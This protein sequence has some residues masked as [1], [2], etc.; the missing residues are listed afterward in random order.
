MSVSELAVTAT[1]MIDLAWTA[2]AA[3]ARE[4]HWQRIH[5][6]AALAAWLAGLQPTHLHF[7]SEF[8]EHLL[9]V[10]RSLR[11]AMRQAEEAG[12]RFV[13]LTPVASPAVLDRL[14]GLLPMLPA[15]TEVVANDWGVA[16]ELCMR[17]PAL[18]PVAGRVL[19][20]MTKDPR[21]DAGWAGRCGHGLASATTRALFGRLGIR[22]LELDMPVFAED[23]ALEGLPLPAGV[24][25]PYIYVAKG[26]MCRAGG[27][28]VTGAERFAVGR[29]CRKECLSVSAE[30]SRPGR[31]DA[32]PSI[33][34]GNTL[35]S[36]HSDAM[37]QAL[38]RAADAERI[39][40]LVVAGE[41]L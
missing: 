21:V 27:L 38:R 23:G 28:S 16:H 11:Q 29:R 25:L 15:G 31:S 10:E 36:R 32:C 12:L 2:G 14:H 8:C 4:R 18:R 40:R 39:G 5:G 24:H 20:R 3:A 9:P 33:Q 35:F 26:R 7:G 17:F 37:A 30:A 34:L 13:L 19:C 41:P 6:D 22:R 1:R